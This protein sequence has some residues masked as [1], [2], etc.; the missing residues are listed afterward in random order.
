MTKNYGRTEGK[1]A[2]D[3]PIRKQET[4]PGFGNKKTEGPNRP[5]T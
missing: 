1:K 3:R 2:N 4:A 5:S